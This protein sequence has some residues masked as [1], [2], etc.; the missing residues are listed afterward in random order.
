MKHRNGVL[1]AV[2]TAGL[3]GLAWLLWDADS[4]AASAAA[5]PPMASAQASLTP[6]AAA[7]NTASAPW[8]ST[9][10]QARRQQLQQAQERYERTTQVYTSYRDAT[11]YPHTSRPIAEH[12]D[13]VKPF[14]PVE[15]V[16]ALR[17][18]SGKGVKGVRLRTSQDRVF[19]GGVESVLFSIEAL[20][21]SNRPL[22]LTIERSTAQTLA[23]SATPVTLV[24]AEVPFNDDGTGADIGARDGK[25]SARLSPSAQGFGAFAGTIRLVAKIQA[26]GEQGAIAFDVVYAPDIPATWAGAREALENGSLNFYLKAQV[27]EAGRYV[28]SARVYDANG[29]PFALLQFND[30]VKAGT[31]EFKLQLFG[32]LIRD[33]NP[34]FP[35]SLVDVDGF[36]LRENVFPDRAMMARQAGTVLTS[37]A[38]AVDSFSSAEWSSEERERYLREYGQDMQAALDALNKLQ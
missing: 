4:A 16:K 22:S 37:K 36:L 35:L 17:D 9:G 28:V 30:E 31:Q 34:A 6:R 11:R 14:A 23:D 10:Q 5:N 15:E 20:D 2:T 27:K 13:Q 7:G 26:G 19:L 29:A 25:Y 32:A 1:L 3:L 12:P 24:S 33:K 38:Y 8:S 21:D 18:A